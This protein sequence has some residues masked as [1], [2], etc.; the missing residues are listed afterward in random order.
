MEDIRKSLKGS[1]ISSKGGRT[2]YKRQKQTKDLGTETH[3][4]EGVMKEEKFPHSRKPSQGVSVGN[5]GISEG[6]IT[7][8]EE[9]KKKKQLTTEY[10]PNCNYKQRPRSGTDVRICH[11]RVWA[12]QGGVG[13]IVG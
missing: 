4:G 2:K 12:G 7:R 6:N 3:L 8:R 9:E 11:Q 13:C 10:V 5:F 1:P